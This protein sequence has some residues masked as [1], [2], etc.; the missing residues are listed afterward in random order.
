MTDNNVFSYLVHQP[1]AGRRLKISTAAVQSWF[2]EVSTVLCV[3]E[4][5]TASPGGLFRDHSCLNWPVPCL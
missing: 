1:V 3:I 5:D 4:T 2:L